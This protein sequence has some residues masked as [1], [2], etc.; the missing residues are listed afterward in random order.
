M[1]NIKP[2]ETRYKGYQFRSRLDTHGVPWGYEKEG[3]DLNFGET[4]R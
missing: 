1:L 2:I 4:S 3:F